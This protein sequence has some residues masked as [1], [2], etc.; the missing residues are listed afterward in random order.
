MSYATKQR[1]K[2]D[3][4]TKRK[5]LE[6]DE[7]NIHDLP[8]LRRKRTLALNRLR[9]T[10]EVAES[11]KG[12]KALLNSFLAHYS[13]IPKLCETFEQ[14]HSDILNLI[15]IAAEDCEDLVRKEFDDTYFK[16]ATIHREFAASNV[17]NSEQCTPSF[18]TAA[19][20]SS[21][22]NVR[23][24]KINIPKFSGLIKEWPEFYDIFSSLINNND[25]LSDTERMHYL[26]SCLSG[27]ALGVIRAYPVQG[28]FY[29]EAYQAL[30]TRYKDRREL[31]FTCWKEILNINFKSDLPAEFRRVLDLVSENL[32]ILKG[33]DLPTHQWDFILCYHILSKLDSNT[34][35]A[36]EQTHTATEMPNYQHLLEFL[37]A[38]CEAL[39]RDTHFSSQKRSNASHHRDQDRFQPQLKINNKSMKPKSSSV[40]LSNTHDVKSKNDKPKPQITPVTGTP[41]SLNVKCQFCSEYHSVNHCTRFAQTPVAERIDFAKIHRWCFN[42]LRSSHH[43]RDC[44]S[45]FR[46]RI[47]H[48]R[49]HTLLHQD[50]QDDLPASNSIASSSATHTPIRA[51]T[52]IGDSSVVLLSTATV[53]LRDS[54]DK[55]QSFRALIDSGSQA[56]FITERA[57]AS[58]GIKRVRTS[59]Y[60]R[61]LGQSCSAVSGTVRIEVGAKNKS[62]FTIDALTL[63]SICGKMP[64]TRIDKSSWHH[65]QGLTL[66]DPDFYKPGSVDLLLGAEVFASLLL[67][68]SVDGGPDQPSALNSVFGWLLLG[69]VGCKR[70]IQSFCIT[71]GDLLHEEVKRF[72]ELESFGSSHRLIPADIRCEALFTNRHT[73]DSTGRY[74]VPLP[75]KEEDEDHSFPGS[76]NVA[77]RRFHS[78]E[79][80]LVKNP[81]LYLQY[82]DF[83]KDYLESGH[84]SLVPVDKLQSGRYHIPHHC[85]LRPDS[86]TT[87]LRVVFDASSKDARG[88]SLNDTLLIGPKLQSNIAEI[89]LNFRVHPVV[90]TA[91][92][93]QMYRMIRVDDDSR[94]FQHIFWR[95]DP[96][97]PVQEFQLNTVTYGVSSAPYLACRTIKQLVH[98]EGRDFPLGSKILTTDLYIDDVVTGCDSLNKAARAKSEV[99]ELLKKAKIELRKW[100]SNEPELLADIPPE[101]C[102]AA[103]IP[104]E[105][106]D[107]PTLKVL[108]L[109]WDPRSDCF[110]FVV[111]PQRRKCTKRTILSELA[112]IYD[113]LGFLSP[114]TIIA[115]VLVQRLWILGIGWDEDPPAD[116]VD[117]WN[118]Y[119]EQLPILQS[120]QIPRC[121]SINKLQSCQIHG[122]SD[123]SEA[124]YGA[125]VYLRMTDAD[126]NVQVLFVCSKGRVAPTKSVSLPRLELCAAVLL[127]DLLK[128]VRDVYSPVLPCKGVF[129]WSD[130]TV[131][132]AWLRSHPSRWKAFVANR[133]SH[134]L[135]VSP[136]ALWGHVASQDNP[137]DVV[138]RGQLPSALATN[139]LWWAGPAWLS[140]S[141]SS[142]PHLDDASNADIVAFE[143]KPPRSLLVHG[144][145]PS[146]F[147]NTLLDRYSSIR[148][149][150][151][152]LC[153]WLKFI[154][155]IRHKR[156]CCSDPKSTRIEL[157]NALMMIVKHVQLRHFHTEIRQLRDGVLLSKQMRKL[158]PFLDHSGILRVGGRL[159]RSGLEFEHKHPALLPRKSR[160]TYLIIEAIHR[161]NCHAGVNTMQYLLTQQFWILSSKQ[162][163]RHCLSK[164]IQC[165]KTKPVPLE[166]FMSDLPATRV[167][168]AKPFSVVGTDYGGP[169]RIK[170]A[171]HR[172][173]KIGKA[174]LCLFVCLSTKAVHLETVSDLSTDA[175]LAALR[176]FVGR[177]GRVNIIQSDCGTNYVGASNHLHS[178]M[179]SAAQTENIE[180][181]FNPPSSPHFGGVW[182]IQ[183]KAVKTH[184]FRII[185][186]QTL[187]FEELTTLFVQIEAMLNSRPICPLSSDPNDLNV[188]TPGHF[189]T[190]EP[191]TTV[192]DED[193]TC[194]NI[195]RLSRWQL[196]QRL[197]QDF[198]NRWKSEYLQTLTQRAKWTRH[199]KPLN[200]GSIVIIKTENSVPLHWPLARV[201]ELH[202]SPDG[203][204]RI[205][206]VR[207]VD[208]SRLSRPLAK[209]CP[210]PDPTD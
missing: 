153:V 160:L 144:D 44:R 111:T 7:F 26:V 131:V 27:D 186:E 209:L 206:T 143:E 72:W 164:C 196:I 192:P 55:F 36:Y 128:F 83:M 117:F 122:F 41:P 96:K 169:F 53:Q 184:L 28:T 132:L 15:D 2:R 45:I 68:G 32:N 146:S 166:P 105:D 75:F 5:S 141:S 21:V 123:S 33:L 124:G 60:V 138:S 126:G 50:Q 77:L 67:P 51:L 64:C 180:F 3:P 205:A 175:F 168:Q 151:R 171:K 195:N 11:A 70:E 129:A 90:F 204:V 199:S 185:G 49:H 17:V 81:E 201:E 74:V 71:N 65:I 133:V 69:G 152:I 177:R 154:E 197:Q 59:R 97:L 167:N 34:R 170:L 48:Q 66:A 121:V 149:V 207:T 203:I 39:V 29:R 9:K 1:F 13:V 42:C 16:I 191:L 37:N 187:T 76:R 108:G 86:V 165:Y 183:I 92:M 35:C 150:Q 94:K 200:V 89:L 106:K 193:F 188:L 136:S 134:I 162:A 24:P 47:C 10:L 178:L 157:H 179:K 176:R 130:S 104:L 43:L 80:K 172:G 19:I 20:R 93:R 159:A 98:D 40:F 189:L 140:Q 114:L 23:L 109:K 137:A 120:L 158:N 182:E 174:Y 163:I 88:I 115:K 103:P 82:N 14:A 135:D 63:P 147:V 95:F 202:L 101:H 46:C 58:L 148:K 91:D 79:R 12:D 181:R 173:A 208:G 85:I 118:R 52:S 38:K 156:S 61:G 100:A 8:V 87:K 73:R 62:L 22:C 194:V 112:R 57:I 142:W 54:S 102:L 84:M 4:V 210:L 198:W 139:R 18:T 190:L 30:C 155:F 119:L 127:A 31:A 107:N 6:C 125:V 78:I 56:H 161:E 99:I 113:P 25:A 116:V 110:I 145:V